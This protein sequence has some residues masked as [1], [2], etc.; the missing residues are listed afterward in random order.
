MSLGTKSR[1]FTA[2]DLVIGVA[3][4]ARELV[5]MPLGRLLEMAGR[6]GSRGQLI[7][8]ILC[9]EFSVKYPEP[10]GGSIETTDPTTTAG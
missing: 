1:L 3:A 10:I 9:R 6:N 8:Y 5:D 7:E 2:N 4:R